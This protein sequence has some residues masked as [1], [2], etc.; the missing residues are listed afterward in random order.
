MVTDRL[1]TPVVRMLERSR[2]GRAG[3]R[4]WRR[5]RSR[6]HPQRPRVLCV[7]YLKT[8][9][10]SFGAAMRRLGYRH[11]GYD[12]DLEACRAGGD[13]DRCL[14]WAANFDSLDDLPWLSPDFV[15]AFRTRFPVSRYVL[16]EREENDW[17]RSYL[18]FFGEV[19][20]PDEALQ[21]YR[22]H[23]ARVIEILADEPHVLRLNVCAGEGYERLCPFLGVPV[24]NEPFPWNRPRR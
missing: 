9:T 13:L 6:R 7:G 10:S 23:R 20:P 15:A 3:L 14:E 18:G 8:G 2:A 4:W 24:P 12:R 19:C 5:P 16:L 21:R 17:L 22:G 11:Y 1:L